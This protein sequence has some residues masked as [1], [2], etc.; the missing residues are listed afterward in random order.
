MLEIL[1]L[2]SVGISSYNFRQRV[3][4]ASDI[5]INQQVISSENIKSQECMDK[6]SEWTDT[7]KMKLNVEKSNLVTSELT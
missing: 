2:I 7:K 5:G 3:I 6:L 1:N 4:V